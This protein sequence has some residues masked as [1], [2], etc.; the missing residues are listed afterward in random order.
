MNI[1]DEIKH[2]PTEIP[3]W[4]SMANDR[5]GICIK[6]IYKLFNY[7][8]VDGIKYL[9]DTN[10]FPKP[11]F[12]PVMT[13]RQRKHLHMGVIKLVGDRPDSLKWKKKTI[14]SEILRRQKLL[15]E[16]NNGN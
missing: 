16:W 1:R 13:V 11:D 5:A 10:N 14:I 7:K 8:S 15:K 3:E 12:T 2:I 9:I 4:L 6:D